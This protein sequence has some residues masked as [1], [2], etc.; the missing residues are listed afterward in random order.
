MLPVS[1]LLI[2][3]RLWRLI[4]AF[5]TLFVNGLLTRLWPVCLRAPSLPAVCHKWLLESA[6]YLQQLIFSVFQELL[7]YLNLLESATL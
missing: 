3:G 5:G 1:S 4:S 7:K 2:T 6:A